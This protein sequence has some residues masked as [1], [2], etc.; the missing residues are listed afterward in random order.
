[1]MYSWKHSP[2]GLSSSSRCCDI[3]LPWQGLGKH[4]TEEATVKSE[5][6]KKKRKKKQIKKKKDNSAEEVRYRS[7][8]WEE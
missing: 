3:D 1:M 5:S 8:I 6:E 4:R 7:E 2:G